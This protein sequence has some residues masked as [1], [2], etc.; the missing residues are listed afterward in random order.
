MA[1][2]APDTAL[3]P[4][5]A[6]YAPGVH[7]GDV[8]RPVLAQKPP[9]AHG[10]CVALDEPA[11]GMNASETASLRQLIVSIRDAGTTVLL[12]EHDVRLV[13]GLCDRIAVL[14]QGRLI[15]EGVPAEV[16]CNPAVIEAY[17]GAP[18]EGAP[19]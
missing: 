4:V 8:D 18:A 15:A 5:V 2:H 9:T 12:I 3:S 6:Q 14:D 16:R 7:G 19:A 1:V 17:L 11:A 13:M 10:V